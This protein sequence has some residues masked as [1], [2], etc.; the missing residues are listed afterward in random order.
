[1]VTKV[2][3]VVLHQEA[4]SHDVSVRALTRVRECLRR[5]DGD[6]VCEVAVI[7]SPQLDQ[8]AEG[9]R[10]V[11]L[12]FY[13]IVLAITLEHNRRRIASDDEAPVVVARRIYEMSQNLAGAPAAFSGRLGCPGFVRVPEKIEGGTDGTVEIGGDVSR[14]HMAKNTAAEVREPRHMIQMTGL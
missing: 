1:M 5:G 7:R 2:P 3:H 11:A 8:V 14:S 13:P 6:K 12:A 9:H 10:R 4:Q